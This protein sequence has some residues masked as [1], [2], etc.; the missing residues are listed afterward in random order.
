[1]KKFTGNCLIT[2]MG[3]L[4]HD[5]L[6][7]AMD[8]ALSVDIPFW[9]QLPRLSFYEDM[10]VQISEHFPGMRVY[11][12]QLRVQL[13]QPAFYEEL[14]DYAVKSENDEL[15]KLSP[16]YSV[17][18]DAFLSRDLSAYYAIRGQ[19]IGPIS[20]GMKITTEDLRPIIYNDDVREFLFDFI[21]RKVNV[22]YRQLRA[23]HPNAFV[24]V[25]E[26]GLEIIFGSFAGYTSDRA[27]KDFLRFLE[28]LE[29]PRGV[30]LCGNPDW[31]FLLSGLDLDILSLDV[32]GNGEIF[33][34]YAGEVKQ[35][36]DDGH[37]ICWGIVPTLTEEFSAESVASL[38][39]R[40]EEVWD[41]LAA[42]GISKEL[43]VS[44]AWLAPARCCLINAD[45]HATVENAFA[46]LRAVAEHLRKK[47]GLPPG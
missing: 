28:G 23:V 15:F 29:G 16:A 14:M 21:A 45:G 31:S 8:V 7:Q 32:F 4:P 41:R 18:L 11:E 42:K 20:F 26:P 30:H 2:A 19:T 25:D 47:Y 9:P 17:A 10:Y 33:S 39:A 43:I 13:S 36:L 12:D 35:F 3:I 37:I 22:Q 24:W 44:Q 1:M 34:R 46:S 40:L 5:N 38:A 27:K 6:E